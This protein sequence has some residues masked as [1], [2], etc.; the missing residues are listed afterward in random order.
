MF[1][2]VISVLMIIYIDLK[3]YKLTYKLLLARSP[4]VDSKVN[5]LEIASSTNISQFE[6]INTSPMLIV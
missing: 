4:A 1:N 5:L 6:N 3:I 2:S